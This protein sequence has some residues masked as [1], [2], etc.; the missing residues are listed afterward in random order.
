MAVE[1]K[2][3]HRSIGME[4]MGADLSRPLSDAD[5]ATLQD[6]V[7]RAGLVLLR[8]QEVSAAAQ[9]ALAE[10]FGIPLPPYR[11][12][13]SHPEF[14]EIAML[15]NVADGGK[16]VTYLN[17]GGIEWHTDSPGSSLPPGVSM[18]YCVEST[19]P[20]GG[21]E[22]LFA[23]TVVGYVALPGALKSRLD[24]LTIVHSF[25]IFNDGAATH[26]DTSVTA[27][28]G[29]LRERNKDSHDP[30]V[31]THPATG[32][33]H[34]YVSHS[35]VK[36]IPGMAFE[37]GMELIMEVVGHATR[38]DFVYRHVW[39]PGDMVV[40]DNRG[41]LHTPTRYDFLDYPRTRRLLRHMI[42]GARV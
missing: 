22:T 42:V 24:D 27:Q 9:M 1:L 36:D 12:E 34:I 5:F 30:I 10:R 7:H 6:A 17:T 41:C 25:N 39:R 26:D 20:G 33:K 11:P 19:I 21:G 2:P 29:A 28:S 23:S 16:V 3:L 8:D 4:A 32:E 14:G 15:G 13:F 38:P 37:E 40:L 35:M 18:L 31:Q